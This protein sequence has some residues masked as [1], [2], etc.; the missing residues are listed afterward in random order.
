ME[1]A[2]E[3]AIIRRAY[4][5]QILAAARVENPHL[6]QA[7]AHGCLLDVRRVKRTRYAEPDV[8]FHSG[9]TPWYN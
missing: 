5:K 2:Q 3:L 6:E 7:F 8:R 4:A 1:R 9:F